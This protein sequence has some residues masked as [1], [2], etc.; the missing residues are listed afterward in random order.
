MRRTTYALALG[1]LLLAGEAEGHPHVWIEMTSS[2][3][4]TDQGLIKGIGLE[5]TFDDAYAAMATEGLDKDGD[6]VFS[7]DELELLTKENVKS[8][9]DFEYFTVMR[10]GGAKQPIGDVENAGQIWSGGKL[11]LHFEVP[12]KT[13]ID[14]AKLQFS[15]K[16]YD[17]EF[18][19]AIDYA[20]DDPVDVVGTVPQACKLVVKP[21]PS[22]DE[23]NQTREMLASKGKDW[24]PEEE[25]DFGSMFAQDVLIEC[26][27]S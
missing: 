15:F 23:I 11:K 13:P 24:K 14:P 2:V 19:I 6:G 3:V 20:K 1:A 10:A 27:Q 22:E 9:K 5:W 8:L 21:L 12:L 17:P 18:Y 26:N 7:A 16:I 4:F 25:Q